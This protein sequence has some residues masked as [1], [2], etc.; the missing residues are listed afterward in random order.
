MLTPALSEPLSPS[1]QSSRI[2]KDVGGAPNCLSSLFDVEI[3]LSGCIRQVNVLECWPL[4]IQLCGA[5]FLTEKLQL[6]QLQFQ[7]L[8]KGKVTP[9]AWPENLRAEVKVGPMVVS[10]KGQVFQP[11]TSCRT[12]HHD[13]LHVKTCNSQTVVWRTCLPQRKTTYLELILLCYRFTITR[14]PGGLPF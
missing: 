5:G 8:D 12:S 2:T 14:Y 13:F 6:R 4:W 3:R 10:L 9:V 1:R 11:F 7:F